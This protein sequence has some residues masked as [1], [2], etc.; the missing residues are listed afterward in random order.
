M[1]P[2]INKTIFLTSL[3]TMIILC[4]YSPAGD[5]RTDDTALAVIGG[6][7]INVEDFKAEMK[8]RGQNLSKS[9]SSFQQRNTLLEEMIRSEMLYAAALKEGYDRRPEILEA[10]KRIIINRFMEDKLEP[11]YGKIKAEEKEIEAYY[12]KHPDKYM[13]PQMV[14]WALIRIDVPRKAS[15]EKRAELL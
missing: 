15:D 7:E 5:S 2:I 12:Q 9:L 1:K 13:T 3:F 6:S 11:E 8:R 14:R 4:G 10:L